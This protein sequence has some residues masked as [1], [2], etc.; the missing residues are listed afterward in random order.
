MSTAI[1]LAVTTPSAACDPGRAA[2][3]H[4]AQSWP[5]RPPSRIT[6]LTGLAHQPTGDTVQPDPAGSVSRFWLLWIKRR[7]FGARRGRAHAASG[8]SPPA[9]ALG[10]CS[11]AT[12][13]ASGGASR[14]RDDGPVWLRRSGARGLC[15]FPPAIQPS[16]DLSGATPR[17]QGR[18]SSGALHLGPSGVA[19]SRDA[20]AERQTGRRNKRCC[21]PRVGMRDQTRWVSPLH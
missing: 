8:R 15:V 9:P 20:W 7:A 5:N 10:V 12:S 18:T 19:R 3:R 14:L 17:G 4:R 6:W 21:C 1:R 11:R 13:I 2:R 16:Q